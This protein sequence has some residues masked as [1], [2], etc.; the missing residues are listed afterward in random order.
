M[1]LVMQFRKV[2]L[3]ASST[4]I[5]ADQGIFRSAITPNYSSVPML[6]RLSPSLALVDQVH[7]CAKA[8]SF[9]CLTQRGIRSNYRFLCCSTEMGGCWTCHRRTHEGSVVCRNFSIFGPPIGS[10][11]PW[12][13][14][15]S[16][17]SL[18]AVPRLLTFQ[19]LFC[20]FFPPLSGYVAK[21]RTPPSYRSLDL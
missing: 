17:P 14:E 1:N 15:V 8:N 4:T 9:P 19:R 20:L 10:I 6:S 21:R 16:S 12:M 2:C 11:V 13:P 3:H 5:L 7:C 18:H